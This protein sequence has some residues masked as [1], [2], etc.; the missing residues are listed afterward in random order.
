MY[1]DGLQE[2]M[3]A[4]KLICTPLPAG[5][6]TEQWEMSGNN[7]VVSKFYILPE[8]ELGRGA[9]LSGQEIL[10]NGVAA[11]KF[12]YCLKSRVVWTAGVGRDGWTLWR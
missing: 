5:T 10:T 9:K 8:G 1:F 12:I 11:R 4:R 6:S 7:K 3:G 2:L